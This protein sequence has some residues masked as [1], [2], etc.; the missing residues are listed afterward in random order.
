MSYF[1]I[2]KYF[3]QIRRGPADKLYAMRVFP[4]FLILFPLF[5]YGGSH[6]GH[7]SSSYRQYRGNGAPP[8]AHGPR[9][10]AGQSDQRDIQG[11]QRE[12]VGMKELLRCHKHDGLHYIGGIE[13]A[14]SAGCKAQEAVESSCGQGFADN[15]FE[16]Y[17]RL[18][19]M[20]Q[21]LR[22]PSPKYGGARNA[23][24]VRHKQ[25]IQSG[26]YQELCDCRRNIETT[27]A[28]LRHEIGLP[29]LKRSYKEEKIDDFI[30]THKEDQDKSRIVSLAEEAQ[31]NFNALKE[32]YKN[33][34]GMRAG[35][36][37]EW[38]PESGG[39]RC[40]P[41]SG[42]VLLFT[43]TTGY[44]GNCIYLSRLHDSY[45]NSLRNYQD[46]YNKIGINQCKKTNCDDGLEQKLKESSGYLGL[47]EICGEGFS[48]GL[49]CCGSL[50]CSGSRELSAQLDSFISSG[51]ASFQKACGGDSAAYQDVLDSALHE[52]Q[53]LCQESKPACVNKCEN[54]LDQFK[55]DFRECFVSGDI[56]DFLR[57][58]R[59]KREQQTPCEER[60]IEISN[61]YREELEKFHK[62]QAAAAA[63]LPV[64]NF[65]KGMLGHSGN[66]NL[67]LSNHS[68]HEDII[69]CSLIK[70][71]PQASANSA[72]ANAASRANMAQAVNRICK[73]RYGA[74]ASPYQ[75]QYPGQSAGQYPGQNSQYSGQNT[76]QYYSGE[77]SSTS[78][79]GSSSPGS[80]ASSKASAQPSSA[81][82]GSA[83]A[84]PVFSPPEFH[85]NQASSPVLSKKGLFPN[86][87]NRD[88]ASDPAN[89]DLPDAGEFA[90]GE[91]DGSGAFGGAESDAAAAADPSDAGGLE[92]IGDEDVTLE[93]KSIISK[94]KSLAAKAKAWGAGFVR[95]TSKIF[96][97]K[98]SKRNRAGGKA[99]DL[100]FDFGSSDADSEARSPASSKSPSYW[101]PGQT[102]F[103]H[104]SRM[105][106]LYFETEGDFETNEA[107]SK[108]NPSENKA[109]YQPL[110]AEIQK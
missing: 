109:L 26:I 17:Q 16:R 45:L 7:S 8:A 4:L 59:N 87:K 96:R 107:K 90:S 18:S 9:T 91:D 106:R 22:S 66:K 71:A 50:D 34:F 85:G 33:C 82:A 70:Q 97:P 49:S 15:I 11:S 48:T 21:R 65:H 27:F 10:V 19:G 62:N 68:S 40:N 23:G 84:K 3:F 93:E 103:E 35:P 30:R 78:Y 39:S 43:Q 53:S 95:K 44:A 77:S 29:E 56:G 104:H 73:E 47:F 105:L 57:K 6:E 74:G 86:S 80:R 42:S 31:S 28:N 25:R 51:G 110:P 88:P 81:L 92:S 98:R 38:P 37:V 20:E 75:N 5:G 79:S 52:Q 101:K 13:E 63:N 41:D 14:V 54:A 72:Q 76:G 32:S 94:T 64:Q 58:T 55:K 24:L 1:E 46:A 108:K 99:P 60:A 2:S 89:G 12:L 67:S 69:K 83:S 61:L 100:K 36:H 102:I